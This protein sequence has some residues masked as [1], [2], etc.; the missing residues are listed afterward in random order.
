MLSNDTHHIIPLKVFLSGF[1]MFK[2]NKQIK[3]AFKKS[4]HFFPT[5]FILLHVILLKIV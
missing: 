3:H 1:K 5:L 4:I 2:F